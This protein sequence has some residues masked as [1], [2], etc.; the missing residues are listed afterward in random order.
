MFLKCLHGF[1]PSCVHRLLPGAS[2]CFCVVHLALSINGATELMSCSLY[3]QAWWLACRFKER[4]YHQAYRV[5]SAV[6]VSRRTVCTRLPRLSSHREAYSRCLS[7]V[8]VLRCCDAGLANQDPSFKHVLRVPQLRRG[9][10]V[11]SHL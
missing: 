2:L 7:L 6:A 1:L 8:L 10:V 9:C 3:L 5:S 11:N 4:E